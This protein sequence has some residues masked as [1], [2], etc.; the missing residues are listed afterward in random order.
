VN[1]LVL[2]SGSSTLKFQLV[3]TDAERLAA[4][5]DEKLARGTVERLGGEAV[6]TL[7]AG[8]G[9]ARKTTAPLRD[10]RAAVETGP[11]GAASGSAGG[12]R[13]T[14]SGTAWCTAASAS[15]AR[16]S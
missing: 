14:P 7:R 11:P 4:N 12:P 16:C 10:H 5:T 1:V 13:S 8:D 9:P 2:N 6:L 3:R 15:R